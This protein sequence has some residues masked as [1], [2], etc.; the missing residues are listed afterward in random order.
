MATLHQDTPALAG[1]HLWSPSEPYLYSLV[2]TITANDRPLDQ[3]ITPI[4]IRIIKWPSG[5]GPF[6]INGKSFFI[7][8]VSEYEHV[9]GASHA[10]SDEQIRT[11]IR[12][13][14]SAGFNALRDAHQPHNLL[15]EALPRP[16]WSPLVASIYI[17]YLVRYAGLP[18]KFQSVAQGLG[19]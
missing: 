1:A 3:V 7:N 9:L 10:F 18:P 11:R 2:T 13:I 12:Q 15:Y 14:E 17:P 6:L 4:G 19:A 16:R 5:P 8:G